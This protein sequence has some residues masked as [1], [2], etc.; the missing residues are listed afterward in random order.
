MCHRCG[1]TEHVLI[2]TN[3]RRCAE[4]GETS[5]FVTM[6]AAGT[7]TPTQ[8]EA[9]LDHL[10]SMDRQRDVVFATADFP[11]YGLDERWMGLRSFS[12]WGHSNGVTSHLGL[13]FGNVAD[14]ESSLLR[15]DTHRARHAS[16]LERSLVA[17]TLVMQLGH[18]VDALLDDVPPSRSPTRI[19]TC[20]SRT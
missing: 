20:S 4:C 1:G 18:E 6:R 7:P 3:E 10:R 9:T 5:T 17:R 11:V 12:G 14:R 8:L 15:V 19:P 2:G 16:Q 13:A